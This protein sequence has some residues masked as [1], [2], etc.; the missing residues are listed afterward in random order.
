MWF[1]IKFAVGLVLLILSV[2]SIPND[3]RLFA[4]LFGYAGEW[5]WWNY[6]GII[7]GSIVIIISVYS[8]VQKVWP[9]VAQFPKMPSPKKKDITVKTM[10]FL[11]VPIVI[12][13]F[14]IMLVL[15]DWRRTDAPQLISED[16]A[17]IIIEKLISEDK[18][19][20]ITERCWNQLNE[21]K[22][23]SYTI[24]SPK[25]PFFNNRFLK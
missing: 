5:H 12:G 9:I 4:R 10:K 1:K 13:L 2:P 3:L 6:A 11:F 25:C 22:G 14:V 8:S 19:D 24:L 20:R 21:A 18:A 7:L 16:E 17:E 23:S 15:L